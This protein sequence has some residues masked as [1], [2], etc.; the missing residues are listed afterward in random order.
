MSPPI[1]SAASRYVAG[2]IFKFEREESDAI[3]AVFTS[4]TTNE[5]FVSEWLTVVS[6]LFE[7]STVVMDHA[8][9]TDLIVTGQAD[10]SWDFSLTMEFPERLALESGRPVLVVPNAGHHPELG[11]N[12]LIAWKPTREVARST[13]D[14]L[15]LLK[16]AEQVQILEV[17]QSSDTPLTPDTS[18][19]AALGRHGITPI[20]RSTVAPDSKVG[21]EILSRLAEERADLLVMGVYGHSRV[22]EYVLGGATRYI[23]RHMTVPTLWSH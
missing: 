2:R 6:P 8:R 20:L 14:A 5:P 13:F 15:S 21:D 12:I 19:A 23:A 7:I 17:K 3:A 11:R 4:M 10:P 18:I 22:S 9:S 1:P 16:D